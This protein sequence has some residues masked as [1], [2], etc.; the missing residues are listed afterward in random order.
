MILEPENHYAPRRLRAV[1]CFAAGLATLASLDPAFALLPA[2]LAF[3]L[4]ALALTSAR[5]APARG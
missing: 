1:A 2:A 4:G 3:F 5:A